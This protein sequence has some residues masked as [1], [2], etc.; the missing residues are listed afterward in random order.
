M[1]KKLSLGVLI[2]LFFLG[3]LAMIGWIGF[4]E[5]IRLA[6]QS[7]EQDGEEAKTQTDEREEKDPKLED[8]T[9]IET[10]EEAEK[11]IKRLEGFTRTLEEDN[12][13]TE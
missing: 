4:Q 13:P 11:V 7:L 1:W 12:L 8:H 10:K 3:T 6:V 9:Q 5:R 2:A